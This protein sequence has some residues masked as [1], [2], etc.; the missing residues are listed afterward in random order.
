MER[1]LFPLGKIANVSECIEN[2]FE[3]ISTFSNALR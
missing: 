3:C 1:F 2:V